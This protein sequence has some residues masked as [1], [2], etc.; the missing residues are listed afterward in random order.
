MKIIAVLFVGLLFI[1]SCDQK[2]N[3]VGDYQHIV[4]LENSIKQDPY[5]VT[6]SVA[7]ALINSYLAYSEKYPADTI[8]AEYMFRAG[9]IQRGLGHGEDAVATYDKILT[10]FPNYSKTPIVIFAQA[11][12]YMAELRMGFKA[13][14]KFNEFIDKYPTHPLVGDAKALLATGGL[15][16]DELM[17]YLKEKN[18]DSE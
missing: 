12:I 9:D 5:N 15:T 8:A 4:Q 14:Q 6:D 3:K 18:K 10:K 11:Y 7:N 2:I 17:E 1:T 16:D 13:D